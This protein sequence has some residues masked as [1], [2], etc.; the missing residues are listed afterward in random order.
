MR[1]RLKGVA[2]EGRE[3]DVRLCDNVNVEE[4]GG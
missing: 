4:V 2:F 1:M 3:W